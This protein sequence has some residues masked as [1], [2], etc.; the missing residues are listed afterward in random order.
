[1]LPNT[2]AT[3]AGGITLNSWTFLVLAAVAVVLLRGFRSG[4]PRAFVLLA[5]NVCFLASFVNDPLCVVV[6]GGLIGFTYV[7]A[8]A[9]ARF[10]AGFPTWLFLLFVLG[11]WAFLFL[12][13]D[14]RLGGPLNPFYHHPVAIVGISY[15]V[16]RCLQYFNDAEL[17]EHRSLL[18]LVNFTLFFATLLAGPIE[19]F[20]RFQS[21]H[22]GED[23]DLAEAWLPALHRIANGLL[24]AYVLGNA[25]MPLGIASL[26]MDRTWSTPLLWLGTLI[27]PIL[28]YLNFSGYC[29]IVIG[30][31]RLVGFRLQENFDRPWLACNI[32]DYWNRWHISL[33]QFLR[34]Y[35]FNPLHHCTTYHAPA[36]WQFP[37]VMGI[38][39][40]TML[41]IA[42]WHELTWG[43][44]VFGCLHGVAL[45][46]LQVARRFLWPR[47]ADPVRGLLVHSVPA[48]GVSW[49]VTYLF[50]SVTML[51]WVMGV[52]RACGVIGVLF[53]VS[54]G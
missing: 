1:M 8:E 37:L 46:W 17:H 7:A 13:K 42:L 49:A 52:S 41:L 4:L 14:P 51:F 45:I 25:L 2:S 38:Y 50:V 22:E 6:L 10:Q 44:L 5:V 11:F 23:L 20:E 19:R 54:H 43:F 26:T 33:S 9:R 21:F 16:F 36:R 35:V 48:R 47:L 3:T 32:Q 12:V 24:K 18:Q 40:L 53:R 28:L 31:V 34:D 27:L 29:D 30:L 15:I 39:F